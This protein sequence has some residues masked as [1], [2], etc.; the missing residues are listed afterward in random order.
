MV[1]CTVYKGPERVDP[2]TVAAN[3]TKISICKKCGKEFT[4]GR[5]PITGRFLVRKYCDVCSGLEQTKTV[6]CASCGKPFTVERVNWG[7]FSER[8]YCPDCDITLQKTKKTTCAKCGKEF[9]YGRRTDKSG[10][11]EAPKYCPDCDI[12]NKPT[13]KLICKMCGKEF[14]VERY[15]N[16]R[17]FHEQLYCNECMLNKGILVKCKRCGKVFKKNL[18]YQKQAEVYCSDCHR[19]SWCEKAEKTCMERYGVIYPCLREEC[20]NAKGEMV[21]K[22]NLQFAEE[23]KKRAINYVLEYNKVAQGYSFD[24]YLPEYNLLLELNPTY[25][26]TVLGNHWNDWKYDKSM[27]DYHLRKSELAKSH[28]FRCMHIW[29]WDDWDK[30]LDMLV[31][32]RK[33]YARDFKVGRVAKQDVNAFLE[34]Y[35]LQGSCYGNIVNLGLFDNEG[36]LIQVMTFGRPRYNKNY[37]WELLRLCTKFEYFVVGGAERLFKHF[38]REYNPESVISYCDISKFTGDVYPRLGFTLDKCTKPSKVWSENNYLFGGNSYITDN[39]LRQRG[40]DQL[41]GSKLSPPKIYGKGTNNEELMIKHKY[42]PVYDCGQKVFVYY[43]EE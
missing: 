22:I 2:S 31:P 7:G 23:L 35:H 40:F 18:T 39:L 33:Y 41:V 42:L 15:A 6:I 29:Q 28:G 30:I 14:K 11:K 25:T 12:T 4:V 21:S 32:R 16:T 34:Q 19:I 8:K 27:E 13:K 36:N 5:S 1:D 26:H 17:K 38:V 37:Q 3:P 43:K 10:F 24:F 9:E 20:I